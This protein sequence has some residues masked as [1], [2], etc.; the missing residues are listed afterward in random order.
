MQRAG[1]EVS[2]AP[3]VVGVLINDFEDPDLVTLHVGDC[4]TKFRD[5]RHVQDPAGAV[6]AIE[7]W[8][9]SQDGVI[10]W[11]YLTAC[12]R[13]FMSEIAGAKEA[14]KLRGETEAPITCLE[15]LV[16]I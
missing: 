9:S 4:I 15:C 13:V 8:R 11:V 10:E 7:A 1:I 6:H 5:S 2:V 12:N 16:I 3:G 14:L